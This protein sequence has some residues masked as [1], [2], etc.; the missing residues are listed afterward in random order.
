MST[1][2]LI[3]HIDLMR[4]DLLR[5]RSCPGAT[6]EIRQLC[7]RAITGTKQRVPVIAQRDRAEGRVAE[8]TIERDKLL[9]EL[10]AL[11]GDSEL[12]KHV[13]HTAL[14]DASVRRRIA[15]GG[16]LP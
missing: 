11:K 10:E 16:T 7:D 4:D 12:L 1:S 14:M 3:D 13:G 2:E 6:E 5:I 9:A 8:L 15:N